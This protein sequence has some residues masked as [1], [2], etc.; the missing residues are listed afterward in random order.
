LVVLVFRRRRAAAAALL[1]AMLFAAPGARAEAPGDWLGQSRP[2]RFLLVG[3]K[4]DRYAPGI[5]AEKGLAGQPYHDIFQKA[6]LRYQL[7]V[8]WEVAHPY[9][10][11]LVGGTVGFWQNYG[12]GL[13]AD[14]VTHVVGPSS[15]TTHLNIAPFFAVVTY[16]F[17]VLA[18]RF[19]YLPVIPY[20]QAGLGAGLWTS[21]NGRGEVSTRTGAGGGR[22][23]GWTRGYCTAVGVAVS[24]DAIDP[25]LSREAFMDA[26]VQRTALFAEYG[27]TRLDG[28]R[29]SGVMILNDRAW[30][31]GISVE[32]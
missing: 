7:E 31:F 12:K 25:Q 24:L 9:G 30:R 18:D 20:V 3:F 11:I 26:G 8:D 17:D 4:V 28:F 21:Y 5:D 15:D 14:A 19:R 2:N 27:W 23:S 32:F 6:P 10:A 16:R 1:F 29:K 13:T 22:G